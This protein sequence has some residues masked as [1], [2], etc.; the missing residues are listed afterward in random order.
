MKNDT[1]K[2]NT[3]KYILA[4][5]ALLLLIVDVRVGAF[6]YPAFLAFRTEAPNTVDLVIK[7]VIGDRMMI[8][9]A[10]DL[11]GFIL[12]TIAS[13]MFIK[14]I[15]ENNNITPDKSNKLVKS[16]STVRN[17]AIAGCFIYIAEKLMPMFM[18]GNYRFR[19]GYALYY[20]LL[21][22]ETVVLSTSMMTICNLL[23]NIENHTY[24]NLT[25]IFAMLCVGTFVVARVLYFYELII[26]FIIYYVL[27]ISFFFIA[28]YRLK[29]YN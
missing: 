16:M 27:S 14:H 5:A 6:D 3:M 9:I 20:L 21:V 7:H 23:E 17:W 4:F 19:L 15:R 12:M 26:V 1:T 29:K 28:A 8:D 24:N 22:A 10:S 18:N 13:I 11:V 25:T 2:N